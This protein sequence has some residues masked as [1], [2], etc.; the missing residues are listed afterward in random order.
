MERVVRAKID[1]WRV[2]V[3]CRYEG[4]TRRLSH[5]RPKMLSKLPLE[6]IVLDDFQCLSTNYSGSHY[7]LYHLYGMVYL[8]CQTYIVFLLFTTHLTLYFSTT[9]TITIIIKTIICVL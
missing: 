1:G 2:V 5:N 8:V 6:D 7:Y 4:Q 9:T 3:V